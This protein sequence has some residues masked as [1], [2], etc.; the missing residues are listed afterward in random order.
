MKKIRYRI[1]FSKYISDR[2]DNVLSS[3]VVIATSREEA[4]NILEKTTKVN[5]I[6]S[7]EGF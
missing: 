4:I 5:Y 2:L 1:W 6:I 7:I 3:R